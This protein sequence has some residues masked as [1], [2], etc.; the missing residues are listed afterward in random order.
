V[1]SASRPAVAGTPNETPRW[2]PVI[3]GVFIGYLWALLALGL[4]ALVLGLL[5]VATWTQERGE[6]WLVGPFEPDGPWSVFADAVVAFTVLAVTTFFVV[7]ALSE[8]IQ[9]RVSWLVTFVV[10]A[11]TGYAPFFFFE[12]RLRLSGLVGLLL[13]AALIRGFGLAGT[14]PADFVG[15]V[16]GRLLADGRRRR[17]LF[18]ALA[19]CW[20]AAVGV[21]VA[22]GVTHPVRVSGG[23]DEGKRVTIGGREYSVYRGEPGKAREVMVILHNN[24]FA[25]VTGATIAP[26]PGDTLPVRH[27]SHGMAQTSPFTIQ[28]RSDAE[29]WLAFTIPRC[30]DGMKTLSRLRIRFRIFDREQSQLI[31]LDPEVAARCAPG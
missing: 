8:R 7:R 2:W 10:L 25:D 18:L 12:G 29:V 28:G 16:S 30:E 22:Y 19:V 26:T 23:T 11:V 24:G 27:V 17:Q 4:L 5:G 6:G 21:G 20:A 15:E 13:S 3:S 9:L 31:R 14:Q 1:E